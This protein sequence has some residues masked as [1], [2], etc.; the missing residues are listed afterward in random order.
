MYRLQHCLEWVMRV[1]TSKLTPDSV[2]TYLLHWLSTQPVIV[3][4]SVARACDDQSTVHLDWQLG[5]YSSARVR[6]VWEFNG[7]ML[8][9]SIWFS[10]Q[11]V[12][13]H[14]ANRAVTR[15]LLL[16]RCMKCFGVFFVANT[17]RTSIDRLQAGQI[18]SSTACVSQFSWRALNRGRCSACYVGLGLLS[19][20]VHWCVTHCR[21]A[22][23]SELRSVITLQTQC[24]K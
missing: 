12:R 24:W 21:Q 17:A 7:V 22:A 1:Y 23:C 9:I 13:F 16:R 18:R 15:L 19:H 2:V 20:A 5:G 4:P 3:L 11:F 8:R 10:C 6:N 14:V